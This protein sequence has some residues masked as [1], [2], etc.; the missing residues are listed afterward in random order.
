MTNFG[1]RQQK[2]KKVRKLKALRRKTNNGL[3]IGRRLAEEIA[4]LI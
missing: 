3:Q 4:I 2:A 1:Q